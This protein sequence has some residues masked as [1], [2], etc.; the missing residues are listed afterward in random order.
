MYSIF[1]YSVCYYPPHTPLKPSFHYLGGTIN[2]HSLM[3]FAIL[4][5]L[6]S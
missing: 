1:V 4:R 3:L 6:N 5:K 2:H